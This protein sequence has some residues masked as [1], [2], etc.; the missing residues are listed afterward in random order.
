MKKSKTINV[1]NPVSKESFSL[2]QQTYGALSD[3]EANPLSLISLAS[4]SLSIDLWTGCAWQC[5]YCHTQGC[6]RNLVNGRMPIK[7]DR[8]RGFSFSSVVNALKSSPYFIPG[9]TI[10][11]IG[12]SSTEPLGGIGI[13][14]DVFSLLSEIQDKH[15][16]NN[17]IWIVTKAGVPAYFL[18]KIPEIVKKTKSLILALTANGLNRIIE[19]CQNDRFLN[20]GEAQN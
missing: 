19:P 17:P 14:N 8:I 16:L 2:L 4:S 13:M 6:A 18:S 15:H 11:S 20:A 5:V 1:V 9:E 3:D 12:T 7:A 10:I